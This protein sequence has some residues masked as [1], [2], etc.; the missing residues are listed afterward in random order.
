MNCAS[1]E[2]E[3][4]C[5]RREWKLDMPPGSNFM[6]R[7]ANNMSM[8]LEPCAIFDPHMSEGDFSSQ[9]VIVVG[10]PK[11]KKYLLAG[12]VTAFRSLTYFSLIKRAGLQHS[13]LMRQPDI[14][15]GETPE[16]VIVLEGPD[17]RELLIQYAET[18]KRKMN[19]PDFDTSKNLTGYCSWYY[20]YADVTEKNFLDNVDALSAKRSS[21]FCAGIAQID[22][23][24]QTFQGDWLDQDP[25]WPTPLS[26]IA[27]KAIAGGMRAGIWLMPFQASTASRVFREHRDWFVKDENGEPKVSLGW[28]PAPD[29][30]WACL[31]TTQPAVREHL[32]GIFKTLRS[33]G[34]SYFKL[35]GLSFGLMEGKRSD[36]TATAVSAF[37][38]GMKTI[39][40][41]VPDST[42]LGCCPPFMACLGYIDSARVT[43][44]T[45]ASR[46]PILNVWHMLESRW[47]MFD[48][49]FRADP[50]VL[51]ARS[52]RGTQTLGESRIS[53]LGGILTGIAI[54]SDNLAVMEPERIELLG[55]GAKY[56][57]RNVMP[58]QW[59]LCVWA[60]IFTGTV[61]GC[62]AV[63]VVNDSDSEMS[64][65]LSEIGLREKQV[66]ELLHPMGYISGNTVVV[67]PFDALLLK[68]LA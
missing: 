7:E 1:W 33:W 6:Y 41:A 67:P 12:A 2:K 26:E 42:I 37:R 22:D 64:I 52:D 44:D 32:A 18:V 68:E 17:W 14:M 57:M 29:H 54:T 60:K 40:E 5:Y 27:G 62:K 36:P 28:S 39:R 55:R 21:P 51:I 10:S 59:D 20:Y 24:Y 46:R 11:E 35:D 15:E 61:D 49:L 53:V 47:W 4:N 56:R 23:G 34:Y 9:D 58:L 19:V 8:M 16:E 66:E 38:L 65:N 30:L 45:H 3:K 31:D 50:D 25:S 63:A 43:C 48:R 13:I